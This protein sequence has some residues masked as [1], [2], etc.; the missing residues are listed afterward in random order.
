MNIGV[1]LLTKS[2]HESSE[3]EYR[4]Q[5]NCCFTHLF[6]TRTPTFTPFALV[7]LFVVHTALPLFRI[8]TCNSVYYT[9]IIIIIY[10]LMR[11]IKTA[12][13]NK[14]QLHLIYGIEA[15]DCL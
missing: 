7:R 9:N 11:T 3:N 10:F 13:I 15:A 14:N 1:N 5:E 6:T 12:R 2:H 4:R 8:R